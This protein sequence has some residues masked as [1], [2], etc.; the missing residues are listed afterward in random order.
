VFVD[1][2]S[3]IAKLIQH[4]A[5]ADMVVETPTG[6]IGVECKLVRYPRHLDGAPS[7][8]HWRD[9]FL[10]MWSCSI[11]GQ[12]VKGWMATSTANVLLW[13]QVS[14]L[15]DSV[16][17]WPLPF[18]P[19]RA[20]T[21]QHYFELPRRTVPNVINGRALWTT[22]RLAPIDRVCRDLKVDGFRVD[23]DG[24]VSTLW[25]KPLLRFMREAAE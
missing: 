7:Y 18:G 15:E 14:L 6:V 24:L 2:N 13:G 21:K 11:P 22:G 12:K 9:F 1:H 19:L 5:H 17:C 25:G 10:E 23:L 4:Q 8:R 16:N 3:A 20:W